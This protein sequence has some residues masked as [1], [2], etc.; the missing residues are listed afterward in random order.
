MR[1]ERQALFWTATLVVTVL[2]IYWLK[3]VLLPFVVGMIIAY[4]LNP[5]TERLVRLGLSRLL[6]SAIVVALIVVVLAL[7]VLF[8]VPPLL[9]QLQLLIEGLPA[10]LTW[11]QNMTEGIARELLG[12]RFA[13]YKASLDQAVRGIEVDWSSILPGIAREIWS[14]GMA[15]FSFVS[16]LLITPLVVFYLLV[17]WHRILLRVKSWLPRDQAPTVLRLAG[18]IDAAIGAFIRGQGLVCLI[19]ATLY[20]LGLIWAGLRY[21]LLIGI[22]TGIMSFVPFAGWALGL[23]VS[24]IAVLVQAWPDLLPLYKVLGVFAVIVALDA[25]VLSPQIVGSRV[26]LHPLWLIFA[27]FVFSYALGFIGVLVAVP[28]AAA[29]AVLVRHGLETYLG[30]DVYHGK[31][32]VRAAEGDDG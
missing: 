32:G 30:S 7:A 26:G 28:L 29:M 25:A 5:V 19:L 3:D 13:P 9:V 17:D 14:K 11:L 8:L 1:I 23:I 24:V 12:A 15:V 31:A 27:L 16:L 22:A 18:E 20:A 2:G 21:G 10:T 4:A 6:A